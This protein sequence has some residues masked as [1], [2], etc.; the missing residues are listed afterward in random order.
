M[1]ATYIALA[2]CIYLLLL[3]GVLGYIGAIS[4]ERDRQDRQALRRIDPDVRAR[5]LDM[6]IEQAAE[7]IAA[8]LLVRE[9]EAHLREVAP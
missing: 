3:L 5:A 4:D 6:P 7:F 8:D 9:V 2:V 1:T